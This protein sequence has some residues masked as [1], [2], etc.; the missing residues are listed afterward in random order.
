MRWWWAF[1]V[2]WP[3]RSLEW[4]GPL[5]TSFGQFCSKIFLKIFGNETLEIVSKCPQPLATSLVIFTRK[6]PHY[7]WLF[8]S[9]SW[10]Y[11]FDFFIVV[12]FQTKSRLWFLDIKNSLIF[13]SILQT[14]GPNNNKLLFGP[15]KF[16]QKKHHR[17]ESNMLK[18]IQS[19][20][21]FFLNLQ[22]ISISF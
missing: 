13:F 5:D 21:F 3:K 9:L 10:K 17:L 20:I 12:I 18:E 16:G 19:R 4:P 8:F 11:H 1:L 2:Y 7:M 14:F 6:W 22:F 15:F